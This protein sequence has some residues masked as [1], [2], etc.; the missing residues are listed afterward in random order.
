MSNLPIFSLLL[1]VFRIDLLHQ[2]EYEIGI[3][4]A[5]RGVLT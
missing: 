5:C 3:D 4:I 1:V 2:V